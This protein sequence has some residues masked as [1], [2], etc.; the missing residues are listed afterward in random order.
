MLGFRDALRSVRYESNEEWTAFHGKLTRTQSTAPMMILRNFWVEP[1]P[2]PNDRTFNALLLFGR[3]T[4]VLALI[5]NGVFK[6]QAFSAIAEAMGGG[7]GLIDGRPIF[8][9][10][11]LVHFPLPAA[12]LAASV[13]LDLCGAALVSF[14]LYARVTGIVLAVY[15]T[16]AILIFHGAIRGTHD[17]VTVLRNASLV[18]GC[19]L[20]AASGP[21]WWSL[22]RLRTHRRMSVDA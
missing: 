20:V 14:G 5:P 17:V 18:G 10:Q 3:V 22:D 4:L 19:L 21:G 9:Q 1:V 16:L 8:E 12:F 13:L 6:L 11:L 15:A 2:T 7:A